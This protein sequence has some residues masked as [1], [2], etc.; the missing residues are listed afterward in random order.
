MM[1]LAIP[2]ALLVRI[3]LADG[4]QKYELLALAC[5]MLLLLSFPFFEAPVGFGS[6]LIVAALIARRLPVFRRKGPHVVSIR[7][8]LGASRSLE[9]V[10][11]AR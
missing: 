6:T 5:A 8:D 3:G 10:S 11:S 2:I 4:F 1:V 7:R 9:T